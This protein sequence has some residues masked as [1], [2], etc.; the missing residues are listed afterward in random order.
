MYEIA[1]KE[2]GYRLP[3]SKFEM[4]VFH[5]LDL[6]PSQLYPNSLAF[7][8]AFEIVA[9]YLEITPTIPPFSYTFHLQ[10]SSSKKG[11]PTKHGWVSLKQKH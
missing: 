3:F 11:E 1:F 10:R 5:H 8:L 6:A 9:E 7:I 4:S 2:M